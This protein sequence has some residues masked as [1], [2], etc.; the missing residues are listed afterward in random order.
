MFVAV[1]AAVVPS[2]RVI[3]SLRRASFPGLLMNDPLL[4]LSPPYIPNLWQQNVTSLVS[5][6]LL[7]IP[8]RHYPPNLVSFQPSMD[9][10][11]VRILVFTIQRLDWCLSFRVVNHETHQLRKRGMSGSVRG[12]G[13]SMMLLTIRMRRDG[14]SWTTLQRNSR[15]S[16][17]LVSIFSV[18]Y[19]LLLF[20]T[21]NSTTANNFFPSFPPPCNNR[22]NASLDKGGRKKMISSVIV[23]N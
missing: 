11:S 13:S 7:L 3:R 22:P 5:C 1:T 2:R 19:Y 15:A 8:A 21:P 9:R 12:W 20:A 23:S 10:R 17:P 18:C 4:L 16:A 14:S 6:P